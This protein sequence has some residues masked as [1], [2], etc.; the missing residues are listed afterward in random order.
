MTESIVSETPTVSDGTAGSSASPVLTMK[1]GRTTFL[2]GVHF[3]ETAK[4]T[5]DDKVRKMIRK[6]VEDGNF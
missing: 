5:L 3:S 6:D 4:H 1:S 2:I